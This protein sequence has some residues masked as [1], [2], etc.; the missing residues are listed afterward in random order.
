MTALNYHDQAIR[1]LAS[2]FASE[3]CE[4]AS[5]DDRLQELM[6]DLAFEFV[7]S[8]IPII[9]EIDRIDMAAELIMNTRL[10]H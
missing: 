4:F 7:E 2:G 1:L 10:T 5:S 6:Q 9:K 3:F 8:N